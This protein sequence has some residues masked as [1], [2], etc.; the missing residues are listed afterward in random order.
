MQGHLSSKCK[1]KIHYIVLEAYFNNDY[2]TCTRHS[3]SLF[4]YRT[5]LTKVILKVHP[6]YFYQDSEAKNCILSLL[7]RRMRTVVR[8][9]CPRT[10]PCRVLRIMSILIANF[11]DLSWL[12]F[13]K[14]TERI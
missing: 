5:S 14:I 2:Y 11:F 12:C 6:K 8:Q 13:P 9:G 4:G 1:M 10:I 7:Q 3:L